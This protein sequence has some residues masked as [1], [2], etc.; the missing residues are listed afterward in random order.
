MKKFI[1]IGSGGLAVEVYA[2]LK[3]YY[4]N[5]IK[6]DILGF[7]S[8]EKKRIVI[9][10]KKI[11][12]DDNFLLNKISNINL[13][14][15]IGDVKSRKKIYNKLKR[16]KFF[17]PNIYSSNKKISINDIKIGK[18]NIFCDNS[19]ICPKV[20]IGDFNIINMNAII[21]H[22]CRINS[23]CNLNPG[24]VISG[25]VKIDDLCEI[26]SNS[27]I[28]QNLKINKNSKIG[29]G[30]VLVTNTKIGKTYFGNPARSI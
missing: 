18:G 6:K 16:K 13:V 14:L 27:V 15:A 26:G 22:D 23:Y 4:G 28:H 3:N 24:C 19:L 5:K 10:N 12:G 29:L 1:I 11:L 30:S 21:S 2:T 17:W 9:D 8:N 20:I 7:V 25:Q